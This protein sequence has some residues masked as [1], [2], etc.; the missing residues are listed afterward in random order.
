MASGIAVEIAREMAHRLGRGVRERRLVIGDGAGKHVVDDDRRNGRHEADGSGE[1]RLGDAGATTARFVVCAFEM[2]MKLFMMPQTVPNRPTKGDVEPIVASRP[3]PS[4]IRPG[5]VGLDAV[6]RDGDTLLDAFRRQAAGDIHLRQRGAYHG[7]GR[8]AR[9]ARHRLGGSGQGRRAAQDAEG[10]AHGT[11]GRHQFQ[12]LHQPD[13]PGDDGGEGKAHHHRL[14]DDIG[15]HEHAPRGQVMGQHAGNAFRKLRGLNG[16]Q[17]GAIASG[18]A[19]APWSGRR[20]SGRS[21][22][23]RRRESGGGSRGRRGSGGRGR[24][25]RALRLEGGLRR[26]CGH[27]GGRL[28]RHRRCGHL[29]R[30][31]ERSRSRGGKLGRRS[32]EAGACAAAVCPIRARAAHISTGFSKARARTTGAAVFSRIVIASPASKSMELVWLAIRVRNGWLPA[33]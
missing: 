14:H 27:C 15:G 28:R 11:V 1:Q 32:G 3:V 8:T 17:R 24:R 10:A 7:A 4:T 25:R 33:L 13:G 16:R 30:G 22:S 26:P 23:G 6:E 18:A 21:G 5:G 2:P 9:L 12:C 20:G 19:A 31:R 29:R